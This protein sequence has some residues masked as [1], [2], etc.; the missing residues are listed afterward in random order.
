MGSGMLR[1]ALLKTQGP[2]GSPPILVAV[3]APAMVCVVASFLS[4]PVLS[5]TVLIDVMACVLWVSIIDEAFLDWCSLPASRCG[6]L[7]DR[8]F[9]VV[10]CGLSVDSP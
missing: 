10:S 5:S 1:M 7:M 2:G 3:V 4:V 8:N 9:P 6:L